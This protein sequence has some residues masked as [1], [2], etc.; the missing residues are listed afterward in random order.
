MAAKLTDETQPNEFSSSSKPGRENTS[1]RDA[2]GASDLL[3]QQQHRRRPGTR[4]RAH[5]LLGERAAA[6][7]QH[8]RRRRASSTT[9]SYPKTVRFR[10]HARLWRSCTASTTS[11][12]LLGHL[13][14]LPATRKGAMLAHRRLRRRTQG[15]H[16]AA[17][18]RRDDDLDEPGRLARAG[19]VQV[20]VRVN[21]GDRERRAQATRGEGVGDGCVGEES[22]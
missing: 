17:R 6:P 12:E 19:R 21:E 8:P 10:G 5:L 14:V 2:D 20:R 11:H 7:L 22:T 15:R 13:D 1:D 4:A 3:V 16:A 9:S 18:G